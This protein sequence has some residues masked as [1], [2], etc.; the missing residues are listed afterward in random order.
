[1][2]AQ[3]ALLGE[4]LEVSRPE[5]LPE[6][7]G[8]RSVPPILPPQDGFLFLDKARFAESFA[9]DL[10]PSLAEFRATRRSS[11]ASPRSK[12]P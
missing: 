1:V 10:D 3:H 11:G 6:A 7:L 2:H 9:A 5:L 8:Q 4:V 12:G